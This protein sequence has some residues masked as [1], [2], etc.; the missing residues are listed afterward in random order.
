MEVIF[1]LR[2]KNKLDENGVG[3][4]YRQVVW[5]SIDNTGGGADMWSDLT[6]AYGIMKI[7]MREIIY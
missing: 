1:E 5:Q 4:N 2:L 7:I 3:E 6:E